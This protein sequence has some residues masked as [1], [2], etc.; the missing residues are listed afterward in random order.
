MTE[1]SVIGAKFM[2]GE[3]MIVMAAHHSM[4]SIPVA[5]LAMSSQLC[6]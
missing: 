5:Q 2:A 4:P 3:T 6:C 1:S